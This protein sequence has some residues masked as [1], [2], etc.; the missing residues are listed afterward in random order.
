MQSATASSVMRVRQYGT[1]S[2]LEHQKCPAP[3]DVDPTVLLYI[4]ATQYRLVGTHSSVVGDD[5]NDDS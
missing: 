1:L 2:V 5:D 3:A 4:G